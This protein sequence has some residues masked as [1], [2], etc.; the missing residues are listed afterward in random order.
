MKKII[1]PIIM[2]VCIFAG[3]IASVGA[4][5]HGIT[6]AEHIYTVAGVLNAILCFVGVNAMWKK[7]RDNK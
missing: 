4:V 2:V 3:I 5:E 6:T 7:W 1:T